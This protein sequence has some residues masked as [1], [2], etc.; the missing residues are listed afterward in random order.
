MENLKVLWLKIWQR[1][2]TFLMAVLFPAGVAPL[3]IHGDYVLASTLSIVAVDL[4]ADFFELK[5]EAIVL[6]SRA[7]SSVGGFLLAISLWASGWVFIPIFLLLSTEL[8]ILLILDFWRD[9]G[10]DVYWKDLETLRRPLRFPSVKI[11][12]RKAIESYCNPA[13]VPLAEENDHHDVSKGPCKCG[14]EHKR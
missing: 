6:L 9:T 4:L 12:A 2:I 13:V 7:V 8:G 10:F 5:T 14:H 3:L 1:P 11:N